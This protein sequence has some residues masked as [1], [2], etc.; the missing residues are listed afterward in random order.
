MRRMQ[1]DGHRARSLQ[2]TPQREAVSE[3]TAYRSR[4]EALTFHRSS[5]SPLLSTVRLIDAGGCAAARAVAAW[6]FFTAALHARCT[7]AYTSPAA[8][9]ERPASRSSSSIDGSAGGSGVHESR[10]RRRL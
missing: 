6:S 9:S 10:A 2:A 7:E 3:G 4:A 8:L 5:M 1:L